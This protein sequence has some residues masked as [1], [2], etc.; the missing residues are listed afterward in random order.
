MIAKLVKG[1]E[2]TDKQRREVLSAFVHRHYAI[3]GYY[4]DDNEWMNKHAFYIRKDGH[5]AAVP[6]HCEPDFMAEV[7]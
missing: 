4:A 7:A 6:R 1:C 3:P 5:L 2:L